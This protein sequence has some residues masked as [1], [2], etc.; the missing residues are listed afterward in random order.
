MFYVEVFYIESR[1]CLDIFEETSASKRQIYNLYSW[2]TGAGWAGHKTSLVHRTYIR[3]D[4]HKKLE[5]LLLVSLTSSAR[6]N[7]ALFLAKLHLFSK[8]LENVNKD[9]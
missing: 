8:T 4:T 6:F 5:G 9:I 3:V 1:V 2:S 7:F